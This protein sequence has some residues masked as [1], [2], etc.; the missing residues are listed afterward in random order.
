MASETEVETCEVHHRP[1]AWHA[2]SSCWVYIQPKAVGAR[3]S[4][5][6]WVGFPND[7]GAALEISVRNLNTVLS[8]LS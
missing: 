1:R 4:L 3:V 8:N 2:H 7:A 6:D 5:A